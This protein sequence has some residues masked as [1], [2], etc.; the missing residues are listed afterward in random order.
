M[1]ERKFQIFGM[2]LQSLGFLLLIVSLQLRRV[3]SS[4]LM[5]FWAGFL[6]GISL[7][8]NGVSIYINSKFLLKTTRM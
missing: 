7:V 5:D 6:T 2:L 1:K 8:L 4:D 3:S